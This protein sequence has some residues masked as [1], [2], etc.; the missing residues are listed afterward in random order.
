MKSRVRDQVRVI[1][2]ESD[3]MTHLHDLLL[4]LSRG[5]G[6]IQAYAGHN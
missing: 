5:D 6:E 3:L 4:A 1:R 2:S